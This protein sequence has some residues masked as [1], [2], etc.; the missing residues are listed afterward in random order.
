MLSGIQESVAMFLKN[1]SSSIQ[2]ITDKCHLTKTDATKW[3]SQVEFSKSVQLEP[4]LIQET[5][6][7]LGLVADDTSGFIWN[8]K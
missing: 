5:A 8:P 6:K 3:F 2:K 7:T 4:K 1:E